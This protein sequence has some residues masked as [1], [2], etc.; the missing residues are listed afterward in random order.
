MNGRY[1][2]GR[3]GLQLSTSC[4]SAALTQAWIVSGLEM[5]SVPYAHSNAID[6]ASL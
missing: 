5:H 4:I 6:A 1:M 2:N 3:S